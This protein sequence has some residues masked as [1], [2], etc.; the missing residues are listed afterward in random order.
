MA[1]MS[2]DDKVCRDPRITVLAELLGWSRREVV[3]CLIVDVWAICYDQ[4]TNLISER[5]IDAAAGHVG[6]AKAMIECELATLDRSGK[7]RVAGAGER[8]KYLSHKKRAGREGGLKN[9][10]SRTKVPKQTS[11]SRGS[12]PQAVGNPP[13]PDTASVPDV[14]PV[15]VPDEVQI[16]NSAAP[17]AGGSGSKS[18]PRKSKPIATPAE[19]ATARVV[20][21]KLST[22]SGV[23]YSGA[24]PH[25]GLIA[26]RLREGL[27]ELDLR[28]VVGYCA[29]ELDWKAKPEMVKY[30]RPETLFG[31]QTIHKYLD[32]ARTWAADWMREQQRQALRE[33][34]ALEQQPR[35]ELAP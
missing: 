19:V 23:Q 24:A 25:V 5:I 22:S 30:L 21:D 15:P 33:Q 8:I 35:L 18:R 4:V 14:V 12:T 1:R 2:I 28:A 34:Q 20:L 3:G 31:P 10:E 13:V 11:S 27:S 16:K 32:A 29:N 17:P 7:L 26:N 6:F 9:S